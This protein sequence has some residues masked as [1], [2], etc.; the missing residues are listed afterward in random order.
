MS[1]PDS[2]TENKNATKNEESHRG[3]VS[4]EMADFTCLINI[5]TDYYCSTAEPIAEGEDWKGRPDP[6]VD[7][8]VN[9]AVREA[10]LKQLKKHQ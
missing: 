6:A 8:E 10:F 4:N 1:K 9:E 7:E 2:E 5:I 3:Y